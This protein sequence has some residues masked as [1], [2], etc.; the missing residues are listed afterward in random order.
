MDTEK[1]LESFNE[2]KL[3]IIDDLRA[4]VDVLAAKFNDSNTDYMLDLV[5]ESAE[6]LAALKSLALGSRRDEFDN[7]EFIAW[8]ARAAVIEEMIM[9]REQSLL[10]M[11]N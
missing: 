10:L 11:R 9:H 3:I 8:M 5:T 2:A 6:E 4:R 1:I 7:Q